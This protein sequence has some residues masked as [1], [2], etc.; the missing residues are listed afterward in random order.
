VKTVLVVE[1]TE[2]EL[3]RC[4]FLL[5]TRTRPE[6]DARARPLSMNLGNGRTGHDL[7]SIIGKR[8]RE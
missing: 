7:Y 4:A 6:A 1:P 3:V 8:E 5:A 2:A